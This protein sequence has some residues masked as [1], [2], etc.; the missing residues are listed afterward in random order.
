VVRGIVNVLPSGFI[1]SNAGQLLDFH[2]EVINAGA[3][4]I[5]GGEVRFLEAMVNNAP[6]RITLEDAVVRFSE[7]LTNDGVIA[8]AEGTNNI[9]GA[10]TNNGTV[11][12]A[13]ESVA[14][15]NDNYTDAGTTTILPRGN[16]LFLSNLTFTSASLV[17]LALGGAEGAGD[18]SQIQ[19][20]GAATLAGTLSLNFDPSFTPTSSQSFE[21]IH[22]EGGVTGEFVPPIFPNVQGV[23]YGLVYGPNGLMLDVQVEQ[24][25]LLDGDYNF[26]GVVD[27]GDYTV[28][29]DGFNVTYFQQD[30]DIWRANYGRTAGEVIAAPQSAPSPSSLACLLAGSLALLGRRPKAL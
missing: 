19:V 11:V 10:I 6:G 24:S 4:T 15:F 5:S 26:D 18:S 13:S 2:D 8:S 25:T 21:L 16:A 23:Q 29:R 27:A 30:Y 1:E 17:S 14:V 9:H 3:V 7:P 20:A 22:A 12:V 28:L